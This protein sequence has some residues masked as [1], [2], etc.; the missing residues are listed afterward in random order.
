M[1]NTL[2]EC[3]QA[4]T[5]VFLPIEGP[6][7]LGGRYLTEDVPYALVAMTEIAKLAKVATPVMDSVVVLASA[8]TS[9]DYRKLAEL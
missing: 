9:E 8:L 1:K 7:D 6:N 4:S 2:Y 5:D 3:Y